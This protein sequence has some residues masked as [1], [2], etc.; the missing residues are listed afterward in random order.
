M[1]FFFRNVIFSATSLLLIFSVWKKIT[2]KHLRPRVMRWTSSRNFS[3][4]ETVTKPIVFV[5]VSIIITRRGTCSCLS[6]S[7]VSVVTGEDLENIRVLMSQWTGYDPCKFLLSS[8]NH[9]GRHYIGQAHFRLVVWETGGV[10]TVK[11]LPCGS[12]FSNRRYLES[13]GRD[14]MFLELRRPAEF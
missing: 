7:V 5:D 3:S 1:T 2:I 8:A 4:E 9:Q 11:F 10:Q 6:L 12:Q 14:V 13:E